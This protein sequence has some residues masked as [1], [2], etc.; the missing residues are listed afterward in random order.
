MWGS[1]PQGKK[2]TVLGQHS[3]NNNGECCR[4]SV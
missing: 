1:G 4:D 3:D 2:Y